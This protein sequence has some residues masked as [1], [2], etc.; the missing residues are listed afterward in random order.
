MRTYLSKSGHE[1]ASEL[2]QTIMQSRSRLLHLVNGQVPAKIVDQLFDHTGMGRAVTKLRS[3][4]ENELL[5][6]HP[7]SST[8]VYYPKFTGNGEM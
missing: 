5:R 1:K 4:L 7:E 6:R 3:D 8:E 2:I